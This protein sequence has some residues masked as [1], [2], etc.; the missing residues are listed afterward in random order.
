MLGS[1]RGLLPRKHALHR[2]SVC[3]IAQLK[4]LCSCYCCAF[5]PRTYHRVHR[6]QRADIKAEE[7]SKTKQERPIPPG[8][9]KGL[10]ES[11]TRLLCATHRRK[12]THR[13][14]KRRQTLSPAHLCS[15]SAS[16]ENS[17]GIMADTFS[18]MAST[19]PW[20]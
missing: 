3:A 17:P 11:S 12:G 8:P 13:I 6:A 15:S 2:Y 16:G 5:A 19:I 4:L 14:T 20:R 10:N 7:Q 1:D 18:A 9:A